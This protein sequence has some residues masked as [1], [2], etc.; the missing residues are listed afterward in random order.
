MSHFGHTST[1]PVLLRR[2]GAFGIFEFL[3]I[4]SR[5]AAFAEFDDDLLDFSGELERHLLHV[6][7]DQWRA[8]IF[9]DVEGLVAQGADR[10]G[11]L[12]F[13][14]RAR[15]PSTLSVTMLPLA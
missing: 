2:Q 3:L 7:F 6:V 14:M 4:A 1:L 10:D 11:A 15:L 13:A 9:T 5:R 8:G 12:D